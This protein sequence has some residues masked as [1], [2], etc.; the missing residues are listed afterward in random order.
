MLNFDAVIVD[1][2]D[3]SMNGRHLFAN[4][5][6]TTNSLWALKA[7]M[8]A[9]NVDPDIFE[10]PCDVLEE[11]IALVGNRASAIVTLEPD[12]RPNAGDNMV[13]RTTFKPLD[14]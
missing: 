10:A 4:H 7:T 9:F 11:S 13:N 8:V 14:V 5:V 1:A 3:P 2:D 6:L 12:N